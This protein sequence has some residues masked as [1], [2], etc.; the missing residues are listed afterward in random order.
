MGLA[1]RC[2]GLSVLVLLLAAPAFAESA[3]EILDRSRALDDGPQH[4]VDRRQKLRLRI[5]DRRGV[6][7][8]R[9][10]EMSEKR[11][12]G[13]ERKMILFFSAPPEVDGTGFLSFMHKERAADQ[14]LYVPELQR[15]RQIA[16][17]VRNQSFVGTDL[18]YHDLDIIT[19]INS[20]SEAEAASSLR[21]PESVDGVSCHAIELTPK[22]KDIG[23]EKIV[24]WLGTDDLFP[25]RLE[26]FRSATE[27][28]KRITQSDIRR[29][30]AIPVAYRVNVETL[31]VGSGTT[32][33]VLDV[34][35][36]QNISDDA[37]TQG[38]L[39]HGP[40]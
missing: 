40:Q 14:W 12:P 4:W 6:T 24:V 33:E 27:A 10:L 13:G 25:R 23:Y 7:R 3:R 30:G 35:F 22:R 26:L 36:D 20:W 19:E 5:V 34:R 8:T 37:F 2:C 39:E 38:A 31:G 16:V 28:A 17:S 1:I 29:F 9:E 32:I 21:G 11:Y 18:T 15:V